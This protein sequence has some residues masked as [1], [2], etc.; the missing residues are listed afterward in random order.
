MTGAVHCDKAQQASIVTSGGSEGHRNPTE[1]DPFFYF[2]SI[3]EKFKHLMEV[4]NSTMNSHEPASI[5][6]MWPDLFHPYPPTAHGV[7]FYLFVFVF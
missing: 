7:V 1:L 5:I 6:N 2:F 3:M 4:E